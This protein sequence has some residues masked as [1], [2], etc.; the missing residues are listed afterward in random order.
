MEEEI[1]TAE[2]SLEDLK[3]KAYKCE[4]DQELSEL[5]EKYHKLKE[6]FH[7]IFVRFLTQSVEVNEYNYEKVKTFW[8]KEAG[9]K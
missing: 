2:A 5:T 4:R 1:K 3:K 9:L 7:E 6:A 8:L